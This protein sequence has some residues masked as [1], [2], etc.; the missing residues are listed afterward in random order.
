M[1]GRSDRPRRWRLQRRSSRCRSS[2]DKYF[3]S[4][5]VLWGR[6]S[7][8][9]SAAAW[10][11]V[12][13]VSRSSWH[14]TR[15]TRMASC[16]CLPMRSTCADT[17]HNRAEEQSS[18]HRQSG[19]RAAPPV[20]RGGGTGLRLLP[21][22]SVAPLVTWCGP[23]DE[24]ARRPVIANRASIV[25]RRPFGRCCG[26]VR[27]PLACCQSRSAN[28]LTSTRVLIVVWCRPSDDHLGT[29]RS[30]M[31]SVRRPLAY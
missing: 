2:G 24:R 25:W 27:R 8:R 23:S 9:G 11:N 5:I 20:G 14:G 26:T 18:M 6:P 21:D 22:G 30:L 3:N 15:G 17:L 1:C 31:Q 13:R 28:R 12:C 10:R 29:D 4:L 7:A 19:A 16:L